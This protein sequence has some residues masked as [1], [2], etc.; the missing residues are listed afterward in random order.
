MLAGPFKL[1][2]SPYTKRKIPQIDK[3]KRFHKNHLPH[4]VQVY[5]KSSQSIFDRISL[6]K[7]KMQEIKRKYMLRI[8]NSILLHVEY[9]K[10]NFGKKKIQLYDVKSTFEF[11]LLKIEIMMKNSK[12]DKKVENCNFIY[13]NITL[14]FKTFVSEI[15]FDVKQQISFLDFEIR[16]FDNDVKRYFKK[17][18][19]EFLLDANVM[20]DLTEFKMGI[21]I[22][23]SFYYDKMIS[24]ILA[25][26]DSINQ[27]KCYVN[28]DNAIY[29]NMIINYDIELYGICSFFAF[30]NNINMNY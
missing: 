13:N 22:K 23:T 3:Q 30:L 20:E 9:I 24:H 17:C 7:D 14:D 27:I 11:I 2:V 28:S 12:N 15:I 16:K 8:I 6:I 29:I 25:F 5:E 26:I 4:H 1:S 10:K 18:I 21:E 19:C